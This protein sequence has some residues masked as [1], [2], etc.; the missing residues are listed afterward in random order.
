[1]EIILSKQAIKKLKIIKSWDLS[2]A[3]LIKEKI[4]LISQKKVQF[5]Q[6]QWYQWFYKERV[7]KY[8]IIFSYKENYVYILIL[9]RRDLVYK[10]VSHLL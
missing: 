5:V 1:V 8:R 4:Q 6:L 3:K 2:H 7:W 10:L 9:E